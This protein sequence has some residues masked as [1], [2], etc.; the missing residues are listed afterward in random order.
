MLRE[1]AGRLAGE[2]HAAKRPACGDIETCREQGQKKFEA[3]EEAKG[4][5]VRL[6]SGVR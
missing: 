6:G 3:S 4:P 2:A 5:I 1:D